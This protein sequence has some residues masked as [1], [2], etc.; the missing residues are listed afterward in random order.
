MLIP[1]VQ[2]RPS[3][4]KKLGLRRQSL[5]SSAA[6]AADSSSSAQTSS[7]EDITHPRDPARDTSGFLSLARRRSHAR[8]RRLPSGV[9]PLE[10]GGWARRSL[11]AASTEESNL[12]TPSAASSTEAASATPLA[13]S[14]R[15]GWRT[16]RSRS[17]ILYETFMASSREGQTHQQGS[18]RRQSFFFGRQ[19]SDSAS[20]T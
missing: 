12:V 8:S 7:R 13:R 20:D 5:I 15:A 4:S 17:R 19:R 1:L 9:N 11:P 3:H 10:I 14:A 6:P 16:P 18:T 2:S